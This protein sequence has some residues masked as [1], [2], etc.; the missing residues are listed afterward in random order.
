MHWI[1]TVT[2]DVTVLVFSDCE[3]GRPFGKVVHVEVDVIIFR[4]GVKIGEVHSEQVLWLK[5][6]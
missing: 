1:L 3:Q 2:C 5:G 6:A 4:E